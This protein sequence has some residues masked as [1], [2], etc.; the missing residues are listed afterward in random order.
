MLPSLKEFAAAVLCGVVA[1]IGY[2]IAE[3]FIP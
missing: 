2:K 3:L 1:I